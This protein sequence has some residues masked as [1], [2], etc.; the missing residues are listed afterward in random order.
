MA[1]KYK[2][3]WSASAATDLRQIVASLQER[4]SLDRAKAIF[5]KIRSAAENLHKSPQRGRM[6]PELK[7]QGILLYRELVI[8]SWRLIYRESEKKVYVLAVID[9]RRD[10]VDLLWER[11]TRY[12][13]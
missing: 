5:L 1:S 2:I 13:F 10:A 8:S 9:S 12:S 3:I 4:E 6:V 11:L 7:E